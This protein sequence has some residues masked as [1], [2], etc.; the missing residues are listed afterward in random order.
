M[1][2]KFQLQPQTLVVKLHLDLHLSMYKVDQS[3][4]LLLIHQPQTILFVRIPQLQFS[5]IQHPDQ[6]STQ[7]RARVRES[8]IKDINDF[9]KF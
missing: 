7:I 6:I 3:L 4:P 1:H 2:L 9:G 5:T 8:V